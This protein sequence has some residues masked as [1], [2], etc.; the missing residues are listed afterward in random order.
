MILTEAILE[1]ITSNLDQ[2]RQEITSIHRIVQNY[3][4]K[5]LEST[6]IRMAPHLVC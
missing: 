6:A 2:R 4:G 1:E 5:P 3:V